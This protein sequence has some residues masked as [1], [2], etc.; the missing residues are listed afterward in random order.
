MTVSTTARF[1]RRAC[2]AGV[3]LAAA[4]IRPAAAQ[5][6]ALP[7]SATLAAIAAAVQAQLPKTP[8]VTA[9][10]DGFVITSVDKAYRL[11]IGGYFQIDTRIYGDRPAGTFNT[12]LLR[13]IRPSIEGT[14]NEKYTFRFMPDFGGGSTVLYDAYAEFTPVK[15]IGIR[16][17]KFK[18]PVG[19]ERLDSANALLF[20]ERGLPTQLVA[21]RDLGVQV[22]GDLRDGRVTYAAGVFNGIQDGALGDADVD[23]GKDLV[24]R[25]FLQPFKFT[26]PAPLQ[27]LGLGIAGSSGRHDGTPTAPQL[28]TFRSAGQQ[29]FFRYLADSAPATNK[30]K[31]TFAFGSHRRLNYESWYSYGRFGYQGEYAKVQED[32]KKD[33]TAVTRLA[34]T[35]WVGNFTVLLTPDAARPDGVR[36]AHNFD[37]K[38]GHW[39][40]LELALRFENL[41]VDP[42]AF[43]KFAD[44]AK[45]AKSAKGT[46]YGVNWYFS[47]TYK[48]QVN[49]S[50][51]HF[52]GGAS[53]GGNRATE[54][55][56]QTRFQVKF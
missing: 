50:V 27:G 42:A 22:G 5:T 47:S 55:A 2:V 39:G 26:G 17:G 52:L 15:G 23:N 32:V 13:R 29:T 9:G 45:S 8:T 14:V 7:D 28:T 53:A 11:K 30:N 38:N 37:P 34:H 44:A 12:F 10:K 46:G 24:G 33:S 49:Y 19:L 41:K 48:A 20:I 35:A 43:P 36:P 1:V 56:W 4:G 6:A 51:T 54:K 25:L 40:A 16:T 21:T 3:L 31:T 18:Q